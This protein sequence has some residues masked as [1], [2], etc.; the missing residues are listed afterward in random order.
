MR[1]KVTYGGEGGSK[2]LPSENGVCITGNTGATGE[3]GKGVKKINTHERNF[4]LA[5]WKLYGTNGHSENWTAN[6]S[7]N[8]HINIGDTGYVIGKVTD[9]LDSAGNPVS[10]SLYGTVTEKTS[11]GVRMTSSYVILGGAAG[12]D[13]TNGTNGFN[14]VKL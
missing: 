9:N 8:T 4:T 2:Y 10:A 1:T 11:S 14:F 5:E 6:L 7:D 3:S 13:G 12:K